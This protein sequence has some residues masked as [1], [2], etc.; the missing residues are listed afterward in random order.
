MFIDTKI[1]PEELSPLV[2]A[3]IGDVVYELYVRVLMVERKGIFGVK[4]LHNETVELVKASYQADFFHEIENSL[5][6]EELKIFKKG[7]NSKSPVPKSAAVSD[8]RCSTGLEALIGF[9]YLKNDEKRL[10]EI[11]EKLIDYQESGRE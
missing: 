10:L 6:S 7:R 9:L 2:L 3:Y 4:A 8:Y 5:T 11:F 1:N